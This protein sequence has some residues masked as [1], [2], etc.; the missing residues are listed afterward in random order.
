[1]T[2]NVAVS[3]RVVNVTFPRSLHGDVQYWL[4]ALA[5]YD[6]DESAKAAGLTIGSWYLTAY[7]HISAPGGHSKKIQ[8]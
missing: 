4:D 3:S 5:L 1:M 7:N 6:S 8:V 2:I